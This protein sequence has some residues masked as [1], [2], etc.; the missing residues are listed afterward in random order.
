MGV[1]SHA[2]GGFAD[3]ISTLNFKIELNSNGGNPGQSNFR[4]PQSPMYR[5]LI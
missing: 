2:T 5:C 3:A 4:G 1:I